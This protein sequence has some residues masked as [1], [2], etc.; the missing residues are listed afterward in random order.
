[1]NESL[2]HGSRRAKSGARIAA[3]ALVDLLEHIS[4]KVPLPADSAE[5]LAAAILELVECDFSLS[6][7]EVIGLKG[8]GGVSLPKLIALLRR[9]RMLRALYLS[10]PEWRD[11]RPSAAARMMKISADRYEASRWPRDS[12]DI[13]APSAEPAATWWR[14]LLMGTQIPAPKRLQQILELEIQEGV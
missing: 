13:S 1:M 7:D 8:H 3:I 4:L 6:F 10:Q 12:K 2:D 5:L 11:L 14:I 9:D